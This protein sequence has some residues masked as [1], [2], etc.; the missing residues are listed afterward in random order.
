MARLRRLRQPKYRIGDKPYLYMYDG[1]CM[2]TIT[3]VY[4]L[5]DNYY[6]D[7]DASYYAKDFELVCVSERLLGNNPKPG[8][9]NIVISYYDMQQLYRDYKSTKNQ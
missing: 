7:I 8:K 4:K 9:Y 2:V 3:G 6:Y 1:A 5:G